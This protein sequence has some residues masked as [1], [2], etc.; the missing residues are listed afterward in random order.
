[1]SQPE[2]LR[3]IQFADT[4]LDH[5][6]A[7]AL[8]IQRLGKPTLA[9]DTHYDEDQFSLLS[10]DAERTHRAIVDSVN[11]AFLL[12]SAE[13]RVIVDDPI[14]SFI[15]DLDLPENVR[16]RIHLDETMEARYQTDALMQTWPEIDWTAVHDNTQATVDRFAS[17]HRRAITIAALVLVAIAVFAVLYPYAAIALGVLLAIVALKYILRPTP[18]KHL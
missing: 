2:A 9:G 13:G 4:L 15:P 8:Q 12:A 14:E 10:A 17:Q 18:I 11:Q 7:V 16:V 6:F 3:T 1:M 5:Y